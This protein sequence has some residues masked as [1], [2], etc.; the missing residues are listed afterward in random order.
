[1]TGKLSSNL[2]SVKCL[3]ISWAPNKSC[4]KFSYPIDKAMERPMADQS[5]YRP[6]TQ[7]Q[8]LNMFDEEIPNEVTAEVL[9]ERATKCLATCSF[10]EG[11][12]DGVQW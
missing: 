2:V 8:N 10:C 12:G 4:S 1:M 9:V 6:P 7:S 5:E 3:S 11:V